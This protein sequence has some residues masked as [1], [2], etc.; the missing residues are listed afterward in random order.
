MTKVKR[1]QNGLRNIYN[2]DI[3]SQKADWKQRL[4][5]NSY[6]SSVALWMDANNAGAVL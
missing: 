4:T 5:E 3:F 1:H 2:N 6:E